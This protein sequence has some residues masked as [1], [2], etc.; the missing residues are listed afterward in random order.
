MFNDQPIFEFRGPWGVPVQ[1]GASLFLLAFIFIDL[2][3][4]PEALIYDL[5]FFG[6][7]LLSIFLHELGHAWGCLIQ[8]VPVRRIMIYGGGGFCEHKRAP[9]PREDELIVAMG[10]IV[11]ATLWALSSLAYPYVA[12]PNLAWAVWAFM[13][14]N[15]ALTLLNLLPVMPLDG[16]KLFHLL[17]Q[18]LLPRTLAG[19]VAGFVG[20]VIAVLWIPAMVLCYVE[21]G[22]VLLFVPPFGVHYRMMTARTA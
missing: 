7:V 18:R 4:S 13:W 6:L 2:G 10:P 19:R 17:M 9:G 21:F 12:D 3:S 16:G 15:G 20:L 11:N 14:I 1:I 5:V 8:R 22:L